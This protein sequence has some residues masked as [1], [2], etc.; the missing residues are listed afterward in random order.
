MNLQ[1]EIQQI[2]DAEKGCEV[3]KALA[4]ALEK[5][6]REFTEE[7]MSKELRSIH[8]DLDKNIF[9]LNGKRLEKCSFLNIMYDNGIWSVE[10][11]KDEIYKSPMDHVMEI[12]HE[13]VLD[14]QGIAQVVAKE[15]NR[16]LA[17]NSE[18][19]RSTK[20]GGMYKC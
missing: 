4:G 20:F 5:V 16:Q 3:K 2:E 9:E 15:I 6:E 7:M 18:S 10:I 19:T 13:I 17:A 1:R 8:M 12:K 14:K 11:T